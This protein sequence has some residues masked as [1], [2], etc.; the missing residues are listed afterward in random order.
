MLVITIVMYVTGFRGGAY[1]MKRNFNLSNGCKLTFRDVFA[2]IV[3]LMLKKN[4]LINNW[5]LGMGGKQKKIVI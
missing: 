4:K 1:C 2:F 5:N 3:F